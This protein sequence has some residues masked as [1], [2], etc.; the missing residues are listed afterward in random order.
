MIEGFIRQ[1]APK[2]IV[3]SVQTALIRDVNKKMEIFLGLR[4]TSRH[5]LQWAYQ[6]GFQD[7]GETDRRA[8]VREL[9]EE[10]GVTTTEDQLIFLKDLPPS[11]YFKEVNGRLVR[12]QNAVRV[13]VVNGNMLNPYNASPREHLDMRW[14]SLSEAYDMHQRISARRTDVVDR[15]HVPGTLTPG[16]FKTI[17]WLMGK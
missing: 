17:E 8:G 12:F 16:V 7:P 11:Y 9:E 4:S 2:I 5:T 14:F 3:P 10:V 15:D 13:F 6:G 1:E